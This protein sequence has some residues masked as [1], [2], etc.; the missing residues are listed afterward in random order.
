MERAKRRQN[1]RTSAEWPAADAG[2]SVPARSP[3]FLRAVD[4]PGKE[5]GP[6][7]PPAVRAVLSAAS[8]GRRSGSGPGDDRLLLGDRGCDGSGGPRY[9][10]G[11][12]D[13][14]GRRADP[15][16]DAG[17]RARGGPAGA[18]LRRSGSRTGTG[19]R[20]TGDRAGKP[21]RRDKPKKLPEV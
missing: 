21:V 9:G 6:E 19:S 5:P 2:G 16:A 8:R 18:G 7:L 10:S 20:W 12:R 4:G 3:E 14:P 17:G 11:R 1:D 13:E 15:A